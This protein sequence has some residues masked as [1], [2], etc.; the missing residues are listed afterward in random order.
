MDQPL[1]VQVMG[2]GI[3]LTASG[4]HACEL[5]R[6]IRRVWAR[7]I[8]DP[9]T[10]IASALRIDSASGALP[11]AAATLE[12]CLDDD[13]GV[14]AQASARGAVSATSMLQV[15][16]ELSS[17][18]TQLGL[19]QRVGSA[20]LLHAC[21]LVHPDTGATVLLVAA[22]GTGKTTA[23]RTLGRHFG[24]LTDETAVVELDGSMTP[25]PKPLSLLVDGRRPKEQVAPDELGLQRVTQPGRLAA[26]AVLQ[27][28]PDAE[29]VSV[30]AVPTVEALALLAEQTSSLHLI[31]QPL[32]TVADLLAERGGLRRLVYAECADLVPV[33]TQW[34]EEA[35]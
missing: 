3:H 10:G 9:V 8:D 18:V 13:E 25:F 12:V 31:D 28:E 34:M 29:G 15:M 22:S 4:A 21:A 32:Q 24:Y 16:D 7:C 20:W 27:R 17:R 11:E 35:R 1:V 23:A 19:E 33:V 6:E 5:E 14:V 30:E 2:V 26:V